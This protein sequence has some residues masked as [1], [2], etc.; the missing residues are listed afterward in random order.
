M[1]NLF[2]LYL[3][4]YFRGA[5]SDTEYF[6]SARAQLAEDLTQIV[7]EYVELIKLKVCK[8]ISG[9]VS[10]KK[11][12]VSSPIKHY[13]INFCFYNIK[14]LANQGG[15]SQKFCGSRLIADFGSRKKYRE[16]CVWPLY[17]W[18]C[19]PVLPIS[20][21]RTTFTVPLLWLYVVLV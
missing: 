7:E 15:K 9:R 20:H 13:T 18:R 3:D 16:F 4:T 5:A 17:T 14:Y 8:P 6:A 19:L 2:I 11:S 1:Y 10:S 21:M 12:I